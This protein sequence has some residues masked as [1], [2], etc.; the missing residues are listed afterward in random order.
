M[1]RCGNDPDVRALLDQNYGIAIPSDTWFI[2]A[3]HDT[4]KESVICF[5]E[6]R[7]PP[8][9]KAAWEQAKAIIEEAKGKSAVERC[10]M[11]MLAPSIAR[12]REGLVPNPTNPALAQQ[13]RA[14]ALD[15]VMTRSTFFGEARPELGHAT[16]AS[17][18]IGRREITKG[19]HFGRRAFLPSYDPFNDDDEGNFLQRVI[20]PALVVC[21]GISLEYLFS[22][23]D[24]GAGTKVALNVVGMVGAM[25]GTTGDL[26][27]GLPTQMTEW[28][29]P[30]RI[31][32]LVDAPVSRVQAVLNRAQNLKDIV[33]NE[34]VRLF[35]RDPFTGQLF[36]QRKGEYIPV[37]MD[38]LYNSGSSKETI[39]EQP[40]IERQRAYVN[41][42]T[43]SE[44]L[45][46]GVVALGM[47]A[48]FILPVMNFETMM[49]PRGTLIA[50]AATALSLMNLAFSRNYLH[51]EFM[52]KQFV[53]LSLGLLV[54]FNLV[55]CAP[56][57]EWAVIGWNIIGFSAVFLIGAF[58]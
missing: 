45:I 40:S 1:A 9:C 6:D 56:T 18:V 31:M 12:N 20:T 17:V 44:G 28:H 25:Q 34:W 33:E 16:N 47:L 2:G 4:C 43:N 24:G 27:V 46:T 49:N 57:L 8:Q 37:P 29:A 53:I 58:N 26:Q 3:Y 14:A 36:K 52:F 11:F 39:V 19:L 38:H 51:G 13:A 7:V 41:D 22:T 42:V 32:F 48:S 15:H 54:G 55:A 50:M 5:D 35:V 30:A 23:V 21:S 10:Q